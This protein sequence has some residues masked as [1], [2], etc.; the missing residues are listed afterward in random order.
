M[1]VYGCLKNI[2]NALTIGYFA[3][4]IGYLEAACDVHE[5]GGVSSVQ[6]TLN[7]PRLVTP[8][9]VYQMPDKI[10]HISFMFAVYIHLTP[11]LT[12]F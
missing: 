7:D 4:T 2:V 8:V 6:V 11:D 10:M 1:L 9:S 3:L 12:T 5:N